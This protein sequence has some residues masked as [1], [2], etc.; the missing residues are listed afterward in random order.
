M[1][2]F[3]ARRA[4][5]AKRHHSLPQ[6]VH[7]CTGSAN[8][9]RKGLMTRTLTTR[10]ASSGRLAACMARRAG[11]RAGLP[12][13]TV[14]PLAASTVQSAADK[15]SASVQWLVK[16]LA[17]FRATV[18]AA[19]SHNLLPMQV[20]SGHPPRDIGSDKSQCDSD[21]SSPSAKRVDHNHICG[22]KEA[23]HHRDQVFAQRAAAACAQP[24]LTAAGSSSGGH[25]LF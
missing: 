19:T 9:S 14:S 4:M 3:A 6:T 15:P 25:V 21:G 13:C 1:R 22:T 7:L 23:A 10:C 18:P 17:H 24:M 11:V 2:T 8:A 16:L 20:S 12:Y 5:N